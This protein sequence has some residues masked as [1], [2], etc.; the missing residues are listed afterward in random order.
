MEINNYCLRA[1][2]GKQYP[3]ESPGLGSKKRKGTIKEEIE[4]TED[5]I[6]D[7]QGILLVPMEKFQELGASLKPRGWNRVL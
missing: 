1:L 6:G 3:R 7:E 5:F 2:Q 4:D